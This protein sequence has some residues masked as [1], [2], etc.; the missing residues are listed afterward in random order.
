MNIETYIKITKAM[1][2]II[3][4]TGVYYDGRVLTFE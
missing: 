4:K 3:R 1:H 2:N